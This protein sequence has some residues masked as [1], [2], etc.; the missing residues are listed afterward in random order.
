[1]PKDISTTPFGSGLDTSSQQLLTCPAH[2]RIQDA[3][4]QDSE[5]LCTIQMHLKRQ[6]R[7]LMLGFGGW[8]QLRKETNLNH[9]LRPSWKV[10]LPEV[11]RV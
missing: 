8:K 11:T 1:M 3:S 10:S 5:R 6:R 9:N 4:L 2:Q 7:G